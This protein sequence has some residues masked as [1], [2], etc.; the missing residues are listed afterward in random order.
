MHLETD[1]LVLRDLS[2]ADAELLAELDR[3]P[4][5]M[6]YLAGA[7]PSSDL[8]GREGYFAAVRKRDGEVLGWFEFR[9]LGGG[10]VELGYRLRRA[11]WGNGYATE[12][13]RALIA[14]GFREQ[15][16]TRVVGYTMTVNA[17][18][19]RV[20]EKA[21]LAFVRTFFEEWP[22]PVPDAEHGDVEYALSKDDWN[23]QHGLP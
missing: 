13:A 17:G 4:D 19:R 8:P 12:G 3:D 9:P 2:P 15:G 23:R 6:R 18:S 7:T 10:A 22:D 11:H 1:R 5:V 16:V 14:K 21:G 20:M